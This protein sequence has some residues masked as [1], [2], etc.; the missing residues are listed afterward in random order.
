MQLCH[1]EAAQTWDRNR[2]AQPVNQQQPDLQQMWEE[3]PGVAKL[4]QQT[5]TPTQHAERP[6]AGLPA[7]LEER[8]AEALTGWLERTGRS[9]PPSS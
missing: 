2:R 4:G 3:R 7:K 1:W 8:V 6:L 5:W 9:R